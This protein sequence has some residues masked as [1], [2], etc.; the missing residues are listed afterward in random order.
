MERIMARCN[1]AGTRT[2]KGQI[3]SA[4]KKAQIVLEVLREEQTLS[5]IAS[6]YQITTKTI[7][8][9]KKQFLDNMAKLANSGFYEVK[10]FLQ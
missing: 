7:Q 8:N 4:D 2:K 3:Y 10:K 6:K 1:P 5:Q 9:W